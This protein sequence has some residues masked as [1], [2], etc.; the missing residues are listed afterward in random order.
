MAKENRVVIPDYITA[1]TLAEEADI[2][3]ETASKYTDSKPK[4]NIPDKFVDPVK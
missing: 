4:S 2:M 1:Q 3:D